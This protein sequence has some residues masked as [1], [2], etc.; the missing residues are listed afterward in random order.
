MASNLVADRA[1][2][3]RVVPKLK[4]QF[5]I[6]KEIGDNNNFLSFNKFN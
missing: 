4:A 5:S 3:H 1:I 2:S 6:L